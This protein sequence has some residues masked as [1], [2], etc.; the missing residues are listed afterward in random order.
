MNGSELR[1]ERRVISVAESRAFFGVACETTGQRMSYIPLKNS[2][3]RL[4]AA[5]FDKAGIVFLDGPISVEPDRLSGART[6]ILA[7]DSPS[8]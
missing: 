2:G 7:Y 6:G 8:A 1:I 5:P 3:A 4:G